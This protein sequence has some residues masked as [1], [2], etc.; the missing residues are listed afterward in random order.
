MRLNMRIL[1]Q[2]NVLRR[3]TFELASSGGDEGFMLVHG[4]NLSMIPRICK[5]V[6][7]AMME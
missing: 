5:Q 4:E 7:L 2:N 6:S 1:D 3:G